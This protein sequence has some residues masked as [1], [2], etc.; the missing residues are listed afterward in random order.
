MP[1]DRDPP[2]ETVL[3][4]GAGRGL[5]RALALELA[6]RGLRVAALGRRAE[7]LEHLAAE[8][9]SGGRI[10][11]LVADV[12]DPAE[13]RAAFAEIDRA[14]GP[15][16]ILIGNAAVYPRCDFLDETP[17]SFMRTV[18]VNLGGAATGA[19]LA[20]ERMIP[21]GRG[22]IINVTTFADLAPAQLASAYS[23][24]K[25]AGRI[26][27]R[28]MIADLGDRFPDIVITD[29]IPGALDTEMG[30][31][32]G[33]DPKAAARWGATLALWNDPTLNGAT[34][35]RDNEHLPPQS[36][37]RRLFNLLTGRRPRPRRLSSN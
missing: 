23:V 27:T 5:G 1:L 8:A 18:A 20:L 37:K 28:A 10:L 3:V 35:E 31:P 9:A 33:I 24:S 19:M 22:R 14:L 2:P 29:W 36:L 15:L 7:P 30:L 4:T 25:G 17:E 13:L 21:R 34:F 26:L 11:P 16:D 32:G 6:G 12:A